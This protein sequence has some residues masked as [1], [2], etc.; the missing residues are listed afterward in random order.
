MAASANVAT[1]PLPIATPPFFILYN[2]RPDR[3]V[4]HLGCTDAE[5]VLRT[6][7]ILERRP[8]RFG[9]TE[10]NGC[11][12]SRAKRTAVSADFGSLQVA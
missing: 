11:T 8:D 3:Q 4:P 2:R 1:L 6:L 12:R 5:G 10:G 9:Q 7:L